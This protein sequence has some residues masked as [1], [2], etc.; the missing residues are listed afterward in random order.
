MQ[1][2]GSPPHKKQEVKP[3]TPFPTLFV[4]IMVAITNNIYTIPSIKPKHET[5]N[6]L[7]I[8]LI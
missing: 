5:T 3:P 7:L 1:P 2:T 4:P 8:P 6:N